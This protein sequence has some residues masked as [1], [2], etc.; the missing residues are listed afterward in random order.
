M[1]PDNAMHSVLRSLLHPKSA[2]LP[3]GGSSHEQAAQDA[4]RSRQVQ[5]GGGGR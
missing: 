2:V 3:G 4:A 5:A 1:F